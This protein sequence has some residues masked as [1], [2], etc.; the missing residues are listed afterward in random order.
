MLLLISNR[1]TYRIVQFLP[2]SASLSLCFSLCVS[3]S[4]S[5]SLCLSVYVSLC[6][7]VSFL[8]LSLSSLPGFEIVPESNRV[9]N[10]TRL[11]DSSETCKTCPM[12]E[13]MNETERKLAHWTL[14]ICYE[15]IVIDEIKNPSTP[16]HTK[17]LPVSPDRNSIFFSDTWWC[18]DALWGPV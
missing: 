8:S 4:V 13:I 12:N 7:S 11:M 17:D 14:I 16:N 2:L 15:Y 1:Y 6:L 10:K 5:L 3:L 18:K 9:V